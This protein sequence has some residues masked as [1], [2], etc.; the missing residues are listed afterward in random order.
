LLLVTDTMRDWLDRIIPSGVWHTGLVSAADLSWKVLLTLALFLAFRWLALRA[1]TAVMLPLAG[2][3]RRENGASLARLQTLEGLARSW[4]TYLLLFLAAVTLLNQVGVNVATILAGAGVAGLA[5]SF[6]AQR[7]VRD[8]L[9]GFFLL[10]EDQFRVGEV[11]TLVGTA[12][13]PQFT[14]TVLEMGLRIT[15]IQ[16]VAGKVVTLGNGDIAAVINHSRGPITAA[17]EVGVTNEA[18]LSQVSATVQAVSLP[19]ELFAGPAV[20]QG[21]AALEGER[22]VVRV[23]APAR[24]GKAPEAELALRQAVGEALRRDE[25]A[26]R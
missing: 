18:P 19:D 15:R 22:M 11:V 4:I 24:P 16:D 8:V 25:I 3:A 2:R 7:L 20:V 17:V 23:A 14:G 26:I 6:G 13:L 10:L 9:T 12:G 21:I 1:L 5:L